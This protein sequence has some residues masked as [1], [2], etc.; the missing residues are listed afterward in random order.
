MDD[1]YEIRY[2]QEDILLDRKYAIKVWNEKIVYN[3]S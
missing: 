1:E 2:V 3:S